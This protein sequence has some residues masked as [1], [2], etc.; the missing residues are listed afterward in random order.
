MS[1]IESNT[2]ADIPNHMPKKRSYNDLGYGP[3]VNVSSTLKVLSWNIWLNSNYRKERTQQIITTINRHQPDLIFLQ[4][5]TPDTHKLI[6][7]QLRN[8]YYIFECFQGEGSDYGTCILCNISTVKIVTDSPYYYDY[9]VTKF[10]RRIVGCEIELFK[11]ERQPKF[12]I[13]TTHLESLPENSQTRNIQ[14]NMLDGSCRDFKHCIIAGD[15]QVWSEHEPLAA[16]LRDSRFNDCWV[17]LGCPGKLKYT[18]DSKKNRNARFTQNQAD[19]EHAQC[20]FDRIIYHSNKLKPKTMGLLGRTQ[21]SPDLNVTP[22]NHYG[23][24]AEFDLS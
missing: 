22:S 10:S 14:F 16:S 12:Q 23:L 11:A 19:G 3:K 18:Y 15:F 17:D 7:Q 5:V 21:L 13:V 2:G 9:T 6:E 24:M 4:E 8:S 20:R 1:T